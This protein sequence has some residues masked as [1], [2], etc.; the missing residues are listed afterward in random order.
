MTQL[1]PRNG[2]NNLGNIKRKPLKNSF[3]GWISFFSYEIA[4]IKTMS[5]EGPPSLCLSLCSV[6]HW[7]AKAVATYLGPGG[8]NDT[9]GGNKIKGGKLRRKVRVPAED[10]HD[11]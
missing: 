4:S 5:A 1:L 8:A 2:G 6:C 9:W 10:L 7:N 3:L 11:I